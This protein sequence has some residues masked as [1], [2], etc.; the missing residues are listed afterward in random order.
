MENQINGTYTTTENEVNK[1]C[2]NDK[3]VIII[4]YYLIC[5]IRN[6]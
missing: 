5:D 2:F 4:T 1:H 6:K 3:D